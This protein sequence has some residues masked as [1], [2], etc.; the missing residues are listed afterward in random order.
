MSL[1]IYLSMYLSLLEI[2][3]AILDNKI[4]MKQKL[5]IDYYVSMKQCY[6]CIREST[7]HTWAASVSIYLCI[8]LCMYVSIYRIICL[9]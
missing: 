7:D 2:E 9:L 5:C 4:K 1:F 3:A 8:Y 6:E